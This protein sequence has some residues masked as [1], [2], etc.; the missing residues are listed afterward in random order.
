MCES[1]KKVAEYV[2]QFRDKN[3]KPVYIAVYSAARAAETLEWEQE[4]EE[5]KRREKED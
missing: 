1:C 2:S 3:G 5:E 4:L